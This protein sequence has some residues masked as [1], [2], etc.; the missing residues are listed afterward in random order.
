MITEYT[1]DEDTSFWLDERGKAVPCGQCGDVATT[2]E[3]CPYA[4]EIHYE[5]EWQYVCAKQQCIQDHDSMQYEAAM[6]I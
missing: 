6:D 2:R 4:A 5:T 1:V 3:E